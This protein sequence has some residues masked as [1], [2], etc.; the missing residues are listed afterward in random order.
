MKLTIIGAGCLVLACI[1]LAGCVNTAAPKET[2]AGLTPT[3]TTPAAPSPAFSGPGLQVPSKTVQEIPYTDP[4]LGNA[5]SIPVILSGPTWEIAKG[6]GWT[7]A[8]LTESATL[9]MS[10]CQARQL[11]RDGGRV[12]GIGYDL[13]LIG[14]RCRASTHPDV[15]ATS[16]DFCSD[17]G[18]TL[19]I[20]YHG[21]TVQ[22]IANL[23]TKTV[24]RYSASLPDG[25][26]SDSIGGNEIIR[27]QN[28]TV[29]YTFNR[30]LDSG[31]CSA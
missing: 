4:V 30:S 19:S 26:G 28:S 5:S 18:P 20:D 7:E 22:Y 24:S 8:N 27:F 1:L 12:V 16:C 21:M 25:A 23:G 6:C 14:S 13:N 15:N 2:P 3:I 17:A 9:L 29:F 11:I 31:A 10:D